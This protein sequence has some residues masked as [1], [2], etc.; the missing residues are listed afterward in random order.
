MALAGPGHVA[1]LASRYDVGQRPRRGR[2]LFSTP[3][4]RIQG[5]EWSVMQT[6]VG[7]E[8]EGA[9]RPPITKKLPTPRYREVG[10]QADSLWKL[11]KMALLTYD[12]SRPF[13]LS[14]ISS[15]VDLGRERARY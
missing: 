3:S 12:V 1:A 14:S 5:A 15:L 6:F 11:M 8:C 7:C 13:R 9:D 10:S 2:V 4:P